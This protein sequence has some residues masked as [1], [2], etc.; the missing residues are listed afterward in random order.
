MNVL[1]IAAHPDD[2]ILGC[3]A[4]IFKHSS[5]KDIVNVAIMATGLTS[6]GDTSTE[7]ILELKKSAAKASN[8]LGVSEI[9]FCDKKDNMMDTEPILYIVKDIENLINK[10]EPDIIYSH[11]YSDLNIDHQLISESVQ[12]AARPIP[13]KKFIE[14]RLFEVLSSTEWGRN[15]GKSNFNPNLYIDVSSEMHKKIEALEIYKSEMRNFPHP[16]SY[17][18]V[19]SLAELRGSE[20]GI[21]SAEAFFILR[22]KG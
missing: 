1:V 7:N 10:F 3:G 14:I 15:I 12:I 9:V 21:E 18:I 13:G 4:T 2:E 19:R 11:F 16:R 20:C 6:R 17:R 22:S 8:L 5:K